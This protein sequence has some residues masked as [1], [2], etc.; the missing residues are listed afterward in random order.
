MTNKELEQFFIYVGIAWGK[1]FDMPSDERSL[2]VTSKVWMDFLGD[3]DVDLLMRTVVSMGGHFAPTPGE[4]RA[5]A[6]ERQAFE[7]GERTHDWSEALGKLH[8]LI[9]R[10]GYM[11]PEQA[12]EAAEAFDPAL[13]NAIKYLG[14]IEICSDENEAVFRGQ[15]RKTYETCASRIARERGTPAP[16]LAAYEPNFEQLDEAS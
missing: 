2:A 5:A 1:T 3:L 16:A 6:L 9:S 4:L 14:W 7:A 15:F 12:S 13:A 8:E 11:R 10:F